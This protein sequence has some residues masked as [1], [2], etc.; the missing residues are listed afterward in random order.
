L[1]E[2]NSPRFLQLEDGLDIKEQLQLT[3]KRNKKMRNVHDI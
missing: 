2:N 3:T 1:P